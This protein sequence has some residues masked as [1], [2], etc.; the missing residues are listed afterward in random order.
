[1]MVS[2][3]VSPALKQY[4][5]DELLRAPLLFDQVIEGAID[6]GRRNL[7]AMSTFERNAAGELMQ[8]L[9]SQRGRLSERFVQSLR[10]QVAEELGKAPAPAALPAKTG[11]KAMSLALVE[12]DAVA[13][14]VELSHTIQ[15][16]KSAA[17]HE[18]RELTTFIAALVGDMDV[19]TDHNP[20][21]PDAYARALWAA[22]QTL[23]VTRGHQVTLLRWAATPLGNM[24]RQSYAAACSRLESM[25]VE[26]ASYRTVILP[27]GGRRSRSVESTFGPDLLRMRETMPAPVDTMQAMSYEGQVAPGPRRE[28][29]FDVARGVGNR[30]DRQSV[31]L[32]GRLIEA[33]LQDERVPADVLQLIARLNGPAM[34]LVLRDP[35]VLDKDEHPLWHFIHLLAYEAEMA[36]DPGD[37]ER[38]RLLRLAHHLIEQIA[39]EAEQRSHLYRHAV[40]RLEEFLRQ[41]LARRC[42]AVA[43]QIGAL[44]KF[45][46]QL[47]VDN[48]VPGALDGVLDAPAMET[49]PAELMPEASAAAPSDSASEAWLDKLKAGQWVRMLLGGRWVQAQLLWPGE[50]KEVWLF[51]D[52]ASDATW[53]VR[54]GALLMM[55]SSQLAKTLK[56]RMLVG[57]AAARVQEQLAARGAA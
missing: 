25:G 49:V 38:V 5:D 2:A 20:F 16:V 19:A 34:R 26:P 40:S 54:R 6:H 33:L 14:E 11:A 10:G 30:A 50:K 27:S 8:A 12:E 46:N 18:L 37:P 7:P 28:H 3:R 48:T 44:Q 17:E 36:P 43:T 15:I 4:V 57:S 47:E 23:P 29:W 51:G 35:Q 9:V 55:H 39:N 1:M 42:A 52:G 31:E 45:E 41:R 21:R 22:A 32:V 24:L 13:L 53:A 56:M